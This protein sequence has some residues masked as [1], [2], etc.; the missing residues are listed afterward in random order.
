MYSS[1][2]GQVVKK[3]FLIAVSQPDVV[4]LKQHLWRYWTRSDIVFILYM[5]LAVCWWMMGAGCGCDVG[6]GARLIVHSLM[7][8]YEVPQRIDWEFKWIKTS[9]AVKLAV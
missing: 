7:L 8:A 9:E 1:R 2:L 6:P 3:P 4:G 5:L